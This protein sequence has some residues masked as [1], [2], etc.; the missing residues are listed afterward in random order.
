MKRGEILSAVRRD[1]RTSV[2]AALVLT[3]ILGGVLLLNWKYLYNWALGPFAFDAALA[4]APGQR[5]FVRAEGPLL[6]T[7]LV[8]E[9]T[10]RLFRGAVEN[11]SVSASYMAMLTAGRILVVKVTPEFSGRV[12]LGRLLP[13]PETVRAQ[14]SSDT[15]G[16]SGDSGRG[17]YPYLLEQRG[18]GWLDAN[19]FVI[20]G[21]PLFILAL[22]LL[23]WV[24]WKSAR[25][26]RHDSMK[27]LARLGPL[28]AVV[29]RIETAL[30]MAGR[31]ARVG[32]LWITPE[33]IVG[34]SPTVLV[35]PGSEL[36]GIGLVTS[37]SKSGGRVETKH[38]LHF[39][40]RGEMLSETL[41]V[42]AAEAQA[43]LE[44]AAR[45]MPWATVEDAA[46][47]EKRWAQDRAACAREADECRRA[48][49]AS[50]GPPPT[51]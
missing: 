15:A 21:A 46:L 8:Q 17:F 10:L 6:P 20:V 38:S 5:E 7:G 44:A 37:V 34:L 41:E 35:Y 48:V 29:G 1:N 45:A 18:Y 19:I 2:I 47:F 32:P 43:V 27:R 3:A 33:W 42:S 23:G 50:G 36:V 30:A 11:K 28:P 39:W 31:A 49:K 22:P 9:T 16:A 13:L 4:A 25:V 24:A 12:V 40:A 26:E 51:R 14:L